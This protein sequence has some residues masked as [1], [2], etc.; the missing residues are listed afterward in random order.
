VFAGAGV[1]QGSKLPDFR[2]LCNTIA[3]E[4][5]KQTGDEIRRINASENPED[6][7]DKLERHEYDIRSIVRK[8]FAR[9]EVE[10][11]SL[12]QL[13]VR[14]FA[15]SEESKL[16]TTNYDTLLQRAA[17]RIGYELTP[18]YNPNSPSL[19]PFQG[20]YYAHGCVECDLK[21]LVLTTTDFD[22]A[23]SGASYVGRVLNDMFHQHSALFVGYRVADPY[24]E[25]LEKQWAK[26]QHK[27]YAIVPDSE[28]DVFKRDTIERITYFAGETGDDHSELVQLMGD[29]VEEIQNKKPVIPLAT[30]K[31]PVAISDKDSTT[32]EKVSAAVDYVERGQQIKKLVRDA[33][34]SIVDTQDF[35]LPVLEDVPT[36]RLFAHNALKVEWLLWASEAKVIETLFLANSTLSAAQRVLAQWVAENFVVQHSDEVFNIIRSH[37][38]HINDDFWVLIARQ[39]THG[40]PKPDAKV[41]AKW[42]HF[43][44]RRVPADAEG[45]NSLDFLL[46][47][48][49]EVKIRSAA[50]AVFDYLLTPTSRIE[51]SFSVLRETKEKTEH[52]VRLR[53]DNYWVKE[54]W[55]EYFSKNLDVFWMTLEPI[56]Q[57]HLVAANMMN[58]DFGHANEE[59]D[60]Q[61]FSRSAIEPHEQDSVGYEIDRLINPARDLLDHVFAENVESGWRIAQAWYAT[62]VPLLKRIAIHGIAKAEQIEPEKKID[63]LLNSSALDYTA[64]KTESFLLYKK[65]FRLVTKEAQQRVIDR[66]MKGYKRSGGEDEEEQQSYEVYN[67]LYWLQSVAPE[68]KIAKDAFNDYNKKTNGKWGP[69]EHPDHDTWV[70]STTRVIPESP[71]SA[72]QLVAEPP[73]KHLE[74]ILTIERKSHWGEPGRDGLLMDL[75]KAVTMSFDWSHQLAE[76][77]IREGQWKE[78]VWWRLVDAWRSSVHSEPEWQQILGI[79][80]QSSP[81]Y[82]TT[83]SIGSLLE[84][85]TKR[86]E[87]G[88]TVKLLPE[89][90]VLADEYWKS[91]MVLTRGGEDQMGWLP[92]AINHN[93]GH[94]AEF[95]I[96]ALWKRQ[97]DSAESWAGIPKDYKNRLDAIMGDTSYAAQLARCVFAS[98]VHFFFAIDHQWTR[99]KLVSLFDFDRDERDAEQAW[100]GF[101]FWGKVPHPLIEDF[102]PLFEKA[103]ARLQPGRESHRPRLLDHAVGVAWLKIADESTRSWFYRIIEGITPEERV[104]VARHIRAQ[105]HTMKAED[106]S[107][108]WKKWLG[109]YWS[110]RNQNNPVALSS[111]EADEFMEWLPDLEPMFGDAVKAALGTSGFELYQC[112]LYYGLAKSELPKSH[113]ADV[114]RLLAHLL[115]E[116]SEDFLHCDDVNQIYNTLSKAL[117][118]K[119]L[120]PLLNQ[121]IRLGCQMG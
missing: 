78:D 94:V 104:H 60:S 20:I 51:S 92:E 58:R 95:W 13:L 113:P 86:D 80:R 100:H 33:P 15:G 11:N 65:A 66:A 28:V 35:L 21:N 98:R 105:L 90:E 102:K 49:A 81:L 42:V 8:T 63:W 18:T 25:V 37:G 103:A 19:S 9:K 85:G 39:L 77:L 118:K 52:E 22:D 6:Y 83:V 73:E 5:E 87:G 14:L 3:D 10:P 84:E 79:L 44:L 47:T 40:E 45:R 112:H 48:C 2:G 17:S 41:M 117:S 56:L 64:Y 96:H 97:K 32:Q 24:W 46:K 38:Q 93:A 1:S 57:K 43:L 36:V 108:L 55:E 53:G 69:R 30:A 115:T 99:E 88:L 4:L 82:P 114:N 54:A 59:W 70:S 68:S 12:H 26:S 106:K 72:E 62:G 101:L 75:Q 119:D 107:T 109:P 31:S 67:T 89:A 110:D 71:V 16:I 116:T 50:L 120:E 76:L 91:L 61:S 7:L 121:L 23:Y 29:W 34:S 74:L 27:R 111:D